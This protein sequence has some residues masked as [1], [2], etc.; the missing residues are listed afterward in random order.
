MT[1]AAYAGVVHVDV[2]AAASGRGGA[3]GRRVGDRR[4][5][6]RR[7]GAEDRAAELDRAGQAG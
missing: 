6:R 4:D 5:G 7:A 1:L 2:L 3:G